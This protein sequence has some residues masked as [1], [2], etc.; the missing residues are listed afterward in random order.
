MKVPQKKPQRAASGET[1]PQRRKAESK[2]EAEPPLPMLE[3][4][5]DIESELPIRGRPSKKLLL[6]K[7][8]QRAQLQA[9]KLQSEQKDSPS[10]ATSSS[11]S[12][13][14]SAAASSTGRSKA[15]RSLYKKVDNQTGTKPHSESYVMRL[16]DR[17]LDLSKY[18]DKT[19]LYPICRAWMANQPRNPN[20]AIYKTDGSVPIV[21]REDNAEEILAQLR[22]GEL[23][24]VKQMP[25]PRDTDMDPIPQRLP[26]P[27]H[28][29]SGNLEGASKDKLLASNMTHWKQVRCHRLKH[30]QAYERARYEIINQ[31]ID[32]VCKHK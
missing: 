10:T 11:V 27:N 16:F 30:A 19:P 3:I 14:P 9:A 20:V 24:V 22:S 21:K 7:Q 26:Q 1:T 4:D 25:K 13:S 15:K 18:E 2:E 31:I 17:S 12:A 29:D 8:Q 28:K 32:E 23:K 5:D 6:Q